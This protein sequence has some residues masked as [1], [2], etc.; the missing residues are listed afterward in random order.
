MNKSNELNEEL[1]GVPLVERE[2]ALSKNTKMFGAVLVVLILG[3]LFLQ[4]ITCNQQ[5]YLHKKPNTDAAEMMNAE[6]FSKINTG[7]SIKGRIIRVSNNNRKIIPIDAISVIA[8]DNR[9]FNIPRS[10]ATHTNV[11]CGI[12]IDFRLPVDIFV[13]QIIVDTNMFHQERT[14]ITT[15]KV[16]ILDTD[17]LSLWKNIEPL[18]IQRYNYVLVVKPIIIYPDP[19]QYI[20]S[21]SPEYQQEDILQDILQDIISTQ[22]LK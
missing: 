7:V 10:R 1:Q 4:N 5:S 22:K 2:S 19:H 21:T 6:K 12:N 17:G 16:S 8:R 13:K 9:M 20:D 3:L 18:T 14:A 11:N 15:T